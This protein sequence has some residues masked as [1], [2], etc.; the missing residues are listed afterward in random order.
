M[1]A[2]KY[3]VYGALSILALG[4]GLVLYWLLG[5]AKV[6]DVRNGPVPVRPSVQK[7]DQLV[8]LVVNYCKLQPA[9]G[10]VRRFLVS[11]TVRIPLPL[12]T[13]SG[14]KTCQQVDVPLL[15]PKSVVP[16]V[17]NVHMD[18]QYQVNPLRSIIETIDSQAFTVE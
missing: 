8:F 10:T 2:G 13:D 9:T 17:Y 11:S 6:L 15:I 12:Q 1:R 18:V 16:D 4:V 14:P 3:V 7:P 5:P